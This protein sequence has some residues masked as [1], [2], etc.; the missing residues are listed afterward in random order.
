MVGGVLPQLSTRV[1]MKRHLSHGHKHN[2]LVH[3]LFGVPRPF[4]LVALAVG[5][6]LGEVN[7][8]KD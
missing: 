5:D 4:E 7:D 1:E 6:R 2:I 8:L 3:R